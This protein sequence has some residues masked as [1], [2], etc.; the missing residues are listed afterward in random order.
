[1]NLC[2]NCVQYMVKGNYMG[3][4]GV[5]IVYVCLILMEWRIIATNSDCSILYSDR[6]AINEDNL[7]FSVSR[8]A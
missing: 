6:S 8:S 3:L 1:M 7:S 5:K 4:S 2:D